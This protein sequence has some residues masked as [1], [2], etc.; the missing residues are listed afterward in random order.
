MRMDRSRIDAEAL[1]T[2]TNRGRE[3]GSQLIEFAVASM[4]FL[5]ILFGIIDTARALYA[6][7]FVTYAARAGARYAMVRG[8]ACALLNGNTWCGSATGASAAQ[9]LTYIQSLNL[10]GI[11]PSQININT[12]SSYLWPGGAGC[13]APPNGPGCPVK[14]LVTY[15][16]ASSIPFVR[17]TTI[18]LGAV[19]S[20]VI[21]Q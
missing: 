5:A 6:Y 16:Y 8:S 21:S 13:S 4:V 12:S 15:K 10:P 20:M 19:S 14:V 2:V 7:E 3:R 18:T 1:R 11:D 9:I 17:V